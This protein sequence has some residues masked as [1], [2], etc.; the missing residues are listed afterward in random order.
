MAKGNIPDASTRLSQKVYL[1]KENYQN[2]K[3]KT[4]HCYCKFVFA[5]EV[6]VQERL[7]VQMMSI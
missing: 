2:I 5:L 7:L 4:S 6:L 3:I 1:S